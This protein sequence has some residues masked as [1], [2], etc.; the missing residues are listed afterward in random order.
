[1]SGDH[2]L[3]LGKRTHPQ[4]NMYGQVAVATLCH[5]ENCLRFFLQVIRSTLD[6]VIRS[7]SNEY[8]W[9][10]VV[11]LESTIF[12]SFIMSSTDKLFG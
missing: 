10:T 5:T 6:Q 9:T 2:A 7:I 4:L 12:S 11:F 8:I 1:M 3:L